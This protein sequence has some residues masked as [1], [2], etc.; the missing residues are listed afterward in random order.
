MWNCS[1]MTF[2]KQDEREED[3]LFY[4]YFNFRTGR[5]EKWRK[6]ILARKDCGYR[7]GSAIGLI[8][9]IVSSAIFRTLTVD[10][11]Y[12]EEGLKKELTIKENV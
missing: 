8:G 11:K 10:L 12:T 2:D 3:Y 7:L 4:N 1:D 9:C 6:E 5:F